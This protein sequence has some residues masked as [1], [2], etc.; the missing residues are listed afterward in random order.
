MRKER[1]CIIG[2]GPSGIAAAK[3]FLDKGFFNLTVYDRNEEVGGNWLFDSRSG[4]SSVFETTHIISS[5]LFSQYHDYPMPEDYPDYPSHSQLARYFQG[6]ARHFGVYPYI[7]FQTE[8]SRVSPNPDG[9]WTVETGRAGNRS[10]ATFDAVAVCNGHHWRPRMP[11][12]PGTFSGRMLHSHD[13]KRAADFAGQRVLVIGGG[14]S[15]CDVAVECSRVAAS[16]DISMRRG[17]WVLPKF[18]MGLPVDVLNAKMARRLP[19]IPSGLR[20][21]MMEMTLKLVQ[22]DNAR[23]GLQTPDHHIGQTHPTVN[24]ELLY[25]IRHG[26]VRPRR[27]VARTDGRRVQFV[28]GSSGDFDVIIACTGFWI[29]HPFLDPSVADYSKGPVPLWLKMFDARYRNLFF[30]GMFQPLGCIWP[31]A[32]LQAKV[33]ARLVAGEWQLPGDLERRCRMEAEHPDYRQLNTPRHTITVDYHA[34]RDRLLKEL[35]KDYIQPYPVAHPPPAPQPA[36][37]GR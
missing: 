13:F 10:S 24:S 31:A 20:L 8:V 2:A 30:I 9:S 26:R 34:F 18:L 27:D 37:A 28:D 33:A 21:R 19:F 5:K 32:E 1:I 16:V 25:F 14:N 3:N 35:P 22:G 17:Y 7:R 23:Y 36:P 15:A 6:Y 12:Y 4:H 29:S 11:E